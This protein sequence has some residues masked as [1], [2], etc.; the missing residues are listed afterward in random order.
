MSFNLTASSRI[1]KQPPGAAARRKNPLNQ[2]HRKTSS[3][4]K[5][6]SAS[7][8]P[9]L[10]SSSRSSF[11][12]SL[13][14]PGW[15]T[16][17]FTSAALPANVLEAIAYVLKYQFT[18]L[19]ETLTGLGL[20]RDTI[21]DILNFRRA[22]PPVVPLPH[23]HSLLPS[24]TETERAITAFVA[25][26]TLRRVHIRTGNSTHLEGVMQTDE[27]LKSIAQSTSLEEDTKTALLDLLGTDPSLSTITSDENASNSLPKDA[28]MSLL[29]AGFLTINSSSSSSYSSEN[30]TGG[31][32]IGSG[33]VVVAGPVV[34]ITTLTP[35]TALKSLNHLPQEKDNTHI[36][37]LASLAS[38]SSSS[39][40]GNLRT[41]YNSSIINNNTPASKGGVIEYTLTPP[42]LGLL[43]HLHTSSK[44]HVVDI[45][46][47]CSHRETTMAHLRERWDGGVSK[48]RNKTRK[49]GAE[50]QFEGRTR[51]WKEFKGLT[52][53]W[54][55][56]GLMGMGVVE[57]FD[58]AVGKGIRLVKGN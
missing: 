31:S 8:T 39:R 57:G 25:D 46:R 30:L 49:R 58:T 56:G 54:V 48:N 41:N 7:S 28:I 1:K 5:P 19:P 26:G 4:R 24:P 37:T 34:D 42:H 21:A 40:N 3:P 43:T 33:G 14:S 23:L 27:F 29:S 38:V 15:P 12:S 11:S 20:S 35:T 10:S 45:L 50:V 36:S 47:H 53:D 16:D 52:V 6:A 9:P 2:L 18:P 44:S 22:L 17:F 13:Y 32:G 55:V 51:K